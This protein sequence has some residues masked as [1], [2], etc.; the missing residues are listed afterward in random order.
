MDILFNKKFLNYNE[1]SKYEGGYRIRSFT[2]DYKDFLTT[3]DSVEDILELHS[4]KYF[5]KI[6]R[7]CQNKNELV[8]LHLSPEVFDIALLAVAVSI[9]AS[10][11]G[12]FA[13]VRPS[14]HHAM[15]DKA[16][17]FCLF[18]NMAIAAHRLAKKGVKVAV[19]DLDGH[20]GD[21]TQSLLKNN[22]NI[23]F[24]SIHENRVFPGTGDTSENN[25]VNFPLDT[26]IKEETYF[27]T[28]D[29]AVVKLKGFKPDVLGVSLGL[30]TFKEDRL[31]D[32]E[33]GINSYFQIGMELRM[34][35]KNMFVVLEGGYHDKIKECAESFVKG[36]D[37]TGCSV[38]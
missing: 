28:L 13:L 20:H 30:D 12:N 27:E 33:L 8:G 7:A 15:R 3:Y 11:G 32:F 10:E 26:P 23:M 2:N 19:L 1:R 37:S 34:N 22:E 9:E 17:G 38:R 18:N 35:F 25:Y 36:V 31:L 29:K 24:C 4:D 5:N 16:S 14:G 21:G 6:R